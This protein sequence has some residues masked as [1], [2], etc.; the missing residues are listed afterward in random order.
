MSLRPVSIVVRLAISLS[1][2]VGASGCMV[3]DLEGDV[4]T[5]LC[6]SNDDCAHL[7]E[8][9]PTDD[10]TSWQ[11]DEL[12]RCRAIP[13][14]DDGDGSPSAICSG[15]AT[16]DCDDDDVTVA[17]GAPELSDALDND[18][19]F[20]V[21][22]VAPVDSV[23][24]IL[25]S[26]LT[27]LEAS[28][29]TRSAGEIDGS[30]AIIEAAPL[31]D[32]SASLLELESTAP[33]M[34]IVRSVGGTE[35]PLAIHG[36]AIERLSTDFVLSA[37]LP[38]GACQ[39]VVVAMVKRETVPSTRAVADFVDQSGTH[40]DR[41]VRDDSGDDCT[42]GDPTSRR[43]RSPVVT[44]S[45]GRAVVAWVAAD[46]AAPACAPVVDA[47]V[48]AHRIEMSGAAIAIGGSSSDRL[49]VT[50]DP[51]PPAMID[52]PGVGVVVA[53][54]DDGELVLVLLEM[55]GGSGRLEPVELVRTPV[56]AGG[57][58]V[59]R[60][61]LALGGV[62]EGR[63]TLAALLAVGP[64]E[65]GSPV[66]IRFALGTRDKALY[67]TTRLDATPIRIDTSDGH[68]RGHAFVHSSI[69]LGYW[70]AWIDGPTL[71]ERGVTCDGVPL[72]AAP[73][74]ATSSLVASFETIGMLGP[75]SSGTPS[76]TLGG[77][78]TLSSGTQVVFKRTFLFP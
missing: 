17:P 1:L 27:P 47:P 48:L 70:V 54:V 60:P 50:D 8:S 58:F 68:D 44:S 7:E 12:A 39:R 66:L 75:A 22:E 57:Q 76:L 10:C 55:A 15:D 25:F 29:L 64:C 26:S 6:V 38:D 21:D 45:T 33:L 32:G 61:A 3:L 41:G 31:G 23:D 73:M 42:H 78:G 65:S 16:A 40:F 72:G 71:R 67:P 59:S 36:I 30:L 56:A 46:A 34:S 20:I 28:S 53:F 69:P 51:S 2:G 62:V 24:S 13:N 52:V 35:V 63:P 37:M 18:C 11:C 19:D 74:A 49:G 43:A 14:D 9:K 5:A 77:I 4:P